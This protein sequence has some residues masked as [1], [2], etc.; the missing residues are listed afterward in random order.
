[1]L[2]EAMDA[3]DHVLMRLETRLDGTIGRSM[4]LALGRYAAVI[5][6]G[7]PVAWAISGFKWDR[8]STLGLFA[9]LIL[10]AIIDVARELT[11]PKSNGAG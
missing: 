2:R 11:K 4:R 1:M 6:L 10:Y 3:A 8:T 5:V 7:V 9:G